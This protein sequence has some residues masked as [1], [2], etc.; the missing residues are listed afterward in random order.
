MHCAPEIKMLDT[1]KNGKVYSSLF[2]LL[3][4]IHLN[5]NGFTFECRLVKSG[6]GEVGG[7]GRIALT[8]AS[9]RLKPLK[10]LPFRS[11]EGQWFSK[12]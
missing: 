9:T 6:G 7:M 12:K 2:A 5:F 1:L 3:V 11:G 8:P 10:A 4:K